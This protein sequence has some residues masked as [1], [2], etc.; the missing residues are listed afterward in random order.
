MGVHGMLVCENL[1]CTKWHWDRFVSEHFRVSSHYRSISARYSSFFIYHRRRVILVKNSIIKYT[2]SIFSVAISLNCRV[3]WPRGLRRGSAAAHL[4]RFW[5]RISPEARSLVSVVCCHIEVS[6]SGW[7]L[8][9]RSPTA[10]DVSVCDRKASKMRRPWP[11][12]ASAVW[13]GK[14]N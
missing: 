10:C 7:S 5:F 1:W 11:L 13:G 2:T 4:L 12:E 8:V 3:Q 14:Y 9:Q 6:A